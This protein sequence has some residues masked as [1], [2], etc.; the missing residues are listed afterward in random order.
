MTALEKCRYWLRGCP[1]FWIYTDHRSLES[2]YN[3]KPIDEISDEISNIVVSTYR[4]NLS[5]KYISG[6]DNN[7]ADFL[8]R[9][10]MWCQEQEDHGPWIVDDFGKKITIEAHISSVQA[11][12]RHE[13]RLHSDPLLEHIRDQGAL[14]PQY[15]AVVQAIQQKQSKKWVLNTT[16]NPY[17]EYASVWERLGTLDTRDPTLLTLDIKRLA[18]EFRIKDAATSRR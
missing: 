18:K 2:I 16:D 15:T 1:H 5:V 8:S 7:L 17:R 13:E 9:N 3:S 14:D 12:D 11:I 10:P 6:K 4:Y